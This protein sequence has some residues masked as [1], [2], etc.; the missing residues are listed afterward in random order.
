MKLKGEYSMKSELHETVGPVSLCDLSSPQRRSFVKGI[1]SLGAGLAASPFLLNA[2]QAQSQAPSPASW[3]LP[4]DDVAP[5]VPSSGIGRYF[6]VFY[7]PSQTPGELRIGVNYTLWMP[8]G[9]ET[10]RGVIVHQPAW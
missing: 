7:P 3:G 6:H 8:E 5:I 2:A 10:L 9:I 4:G 1:V